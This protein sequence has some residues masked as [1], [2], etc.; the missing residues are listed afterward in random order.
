MN[1]IELLEGIKAG[2]YDTNI[3]TVC[4][5]ISRLQSP[6]SIRWAQEM[7]DA[8]G[9]F[10]WAVWT[11]E[12]YISAYRHFVTECRKHL[13]DANYVWSPKGGSS[14]VKY[15]PGDN[16]V[17]VIGLSVFGY[18]PYDKRNFGGERTFE[19]ALEPGYKL[20]SGFGK[21]IIVAEL[22]YEGDEEYV[23][24]WAK[25]VAAPHPEFPEL[26]AIVYFNDKEVFAWPQNFGYPNW[27]IGNPKVSDLD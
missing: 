10:I 18:Q 15:Y 26:K 20:V 5:S 3:A 9:K 21:P 12:D 25:A 2:T 19:Q 1:S 14:L 7:E 24:R 22:G 13:P 17:D 4:S 6:I 23:G 8:V 16:Y 27:R 11:P